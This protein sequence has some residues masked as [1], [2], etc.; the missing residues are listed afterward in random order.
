MGHLQPAGD[1]P[2]WRSFIASGTLGALPGCPPVMLRSLSPDPVDS[3]P[4]VAPPLWRALAEVRRGR[5]E[6]AAHAAAL[7]ALAHAPR[8]DGHP[9]FVIPGFLSDAS[10]T[11]PLRDFLGRLGYEVHD[12]GLG[13]NLGPRTAG[14]TGERLTRHFAALASARGRSMTVIGWS[15]GGIMA[16]QLARRAPQH[17]RRVVTLGAP[18][19]GDP[20]ATTAS[21]LYQLLTGQRFSDP[22]FQEMLRQSRLPPPVPATS[23]FSKSDG[24]VAWQCCQEPPAPHT[25]N[26]EVDGSHGGLLAHPQA[27]LAIADR[28]A[29]PATACLPDEP[30]VSWWRAVGD[31]FA[32]RRT[33]RN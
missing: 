29:G 16:R 1:G 7:D 31:W 2:P 3:A 5:R 30:P 22:D 21:G 8:G 14:R 27:L 13:L 33:A 32:L 20:R 15:L 28:L 9:V 12:W 11:A 10:A 18:F 25:E 4:V 6:R 19:T 26:I 24:I 23:I 17:V